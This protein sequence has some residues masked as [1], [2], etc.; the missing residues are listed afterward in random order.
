MTSRRVVLQA[1]LGAECVEGTGRALT[2]RGAVDRE[3]ACDV[4]IA[5]SALEHEL[6]HGALIG[7]ES[8]QCGHREA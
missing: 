6:K 5:A 3:Q 7:R 4:V 1:G 8:F 2:N